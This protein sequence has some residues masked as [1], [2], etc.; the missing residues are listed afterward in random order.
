VPG[1][2]KVGIVEEWDDGSMEKKSYGLGVAGLGEGSVAV[3][4]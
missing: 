2:G 4:L 1:N 3:L